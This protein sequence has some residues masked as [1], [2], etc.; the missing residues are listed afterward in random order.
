[1][2]GAAL[3]IRHCRAHGPAPDAPLTAEGAADA[4]ALAAPLRQLGVDAAY[5]SPYARAVSTI[6][7][8]AAACGLPLQID[9]RL[10]ERDMPFLADPAAFE[11]HMAAVFAGSAALQPDEESLSE[12][13]ARGLEALAAIDARGARLPAIATHGQI[14]SAMLRSFDAGFGHAR[15]KALRMPHLFLARIENGRIAGVREILAPSGSA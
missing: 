13:G 11:T 5:A 1:M 14:L 9:A 4:I 10:R 7:P 12:A 3:L 2:M 15:W 8:A 6:A